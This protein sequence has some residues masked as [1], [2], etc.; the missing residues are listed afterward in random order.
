M[1]RLLD[2]TVDPRWDTSFGKRYLASSRF[3]GFCQAAGLRSCSEHELECYERQGWLFPVARLLRPADYVVAYREAELAGESR[4]EVDE[5]HLAFDELDSSLHLPELWRREPTPRDL[6]HPIDAAWGSV[7]ELIRPREEGHLPWESYERDLTIGGT[8]VRCTL[9]QHFYHHWQAYELYFVRCRNRGMYG[10]DSRLIRWPEHWT[11]AD[12]LGLAAGF[13]VTS[14][15]QHL[16]ERRVALAH[17]GQAAN[18]DGYIILSEGQQTQLQGL[19]RQDAREVCLELGAS[20]EGIYGF[21][22]RLFALHHGYELSE[23]V[24]L[25]KTLEYDIWRTVE[26]IEAL[27]GE[28]TERIAEAAGRG[29]YFT[30]PYLAALFPNRRKVVLDKCTRILT[31]LADQEYNRRCPNYAVQE[32]DV[33][34]LVAFLETTELSLFAYVVAEVSD[35]FFARHSW[36]T[37]A[38]FLALKSLSSLPETLIRTII[39]GSND[40]QLTSAHNGLAS[41]SLYRLACLFLQ[42]R[43]QSIWSEYE[44]LN[45]Y[46]DAADEVQL[47]SNLAQLES[48]IGTAQNAGEY[49]GA[50]LALATLLRNFTS[51]HMLEDRALLQGHYLSSVQSIIGTILLT[52]KVAQAQ[53]W[54]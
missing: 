31:G 30:S 3:V 10:E 11:P 4:F 48:E 7:P 28:T 15:F 44:R 17:Q 24:R 53:G 14:R 23:R 19:M 41:T 1:T 37:A 18:Q 29:P 43:E 26:L 49:L 12:C 13:E 27:T 5:A 25:A 46:R 9:A 39:Q 34:A 51:H 21:L 33:R 6:R 42:G 35:A 45:R 38:S 16:R 20:E 8:N 32:A 40:T 54:V 22:D 47:A 52:W 50:T 2:P 36:A